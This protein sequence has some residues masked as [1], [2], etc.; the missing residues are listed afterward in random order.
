MR[1]MRI[2]NVIIKNK[3]PLLTNTKKKKWRL[4]GRGRGRKDLRGTCVKQ[5]AKQ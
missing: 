4:K 1:A 5:D 2:E 3:K